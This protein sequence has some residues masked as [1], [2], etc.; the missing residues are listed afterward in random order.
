M[1]WKQLISTLLILLV[2]VGAGYWAYDRYLAPRPQPTQTAV[3]DTL[4]TPSNSQTGRANPGR[5]T[6]E[7]F[8][9]PD[10]YA[11]LAFQ[12]GGRLAQRLVQEGEFVAAGT[13]LLQL[14]TADFEIAVTQA[15]AH[16]TQAEANLAAAEAG[17]LAAEAA[18]TTA[19]I[20]IEAA[21]TQLELAT[22]VPLTVEIAILESQVAVA[23]AQIEQA[24]AQRDL[25]LDG[26]TAA[27]IQAAE[28]E[29]AAAIAARRPI[30]EAYSEIARLEITGDAEER[31][32]IQLNAAEVRVNAAQ[33]R[34]AELQSGVP[35]GDR[36]AAVAAVQAATARR[37]VAQAELA[38]LLA[39]SKP[40]Q[41]RVAEIGVAQAELVRDD[42]ELMVAQAETAVLQATT[43]VTQAGVALELAQTRLAR[44]TVTAPFAGRVGRI[45]SEVGEIVAPSLPVLTLVA[46]DDWLVKTTDLTELDV[47]A[48]SSGQPVT[49]RVDAIPDERIDGTITA[50]ALTSG[51]TRG[52]VVYE[53]T[54]RLDAAQAARLP[55]RWGMTV[56]VE[57]DVE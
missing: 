8:I 36:Q 23:T 41:V 55:L 29:L 7:G 9:E 27:Q 18:L 34:L 22:S 39:G 54:I 46:A 6:V 43:S 13:P 32:R 30:Q 56:V 19:V 4:T 24:A 48:L 53:A 5:I 3:S 37:D 26:P 11:R 17:L 20:G 47:V 21:Q 1:N 45:D 10:Q 28:A 44:Q 14:D 2:L 12:D 16:L 33:S 50:V 40:E 51:L 31:A 38:L 52:D 57:I 15:A 49:V 35:A 42:V 25:V